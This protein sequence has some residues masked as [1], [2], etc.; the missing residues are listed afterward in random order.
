MVGLHGENQ[1]RA[2]LGDEH[3]GAYGKGSTNRD[4][5]LFPR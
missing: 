5:K 4:V 2:V 1:K 3:P